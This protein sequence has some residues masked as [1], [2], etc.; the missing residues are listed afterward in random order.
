MTTLT[1]LALLASVSFCCLLGAAEIPGTAASAQS[2]FGLNCKRSIRCSKISGGKCP[3]TNLSAGD[4]PFNLAA[5]WTPS[6]NTGV[7]TLDEDGVVIGPITF[8]STFTLNTN[9]TF[10]TTWTSSTF[11]K[12]KFYGALT[13]FSSGVAK[14]FRGV[15]TDT[16]DSAACDGDAQ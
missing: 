4:G 15:A 12:Q 3:S 13:S 14:K 5:L 1:K 11:G 6:S 16:F 10:T 2:I 8:T 9:G 7:E